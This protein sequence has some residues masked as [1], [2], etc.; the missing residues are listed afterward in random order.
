MLIDF[1]ICSLFLFIEI[2]SEGKNI[3]KGKY[4][5]NSFVCG[6]LILNARDYI[7]RQL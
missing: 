4:E 7:C 3:E 6:Y 1:G 5:H 2:E